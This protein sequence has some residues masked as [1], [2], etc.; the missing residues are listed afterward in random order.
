MQPRDKLRLQPDERLAFLQGFLRRPQQVG[1][2]IPSSRFLERRLVALADVK[3]AR[4][5][6]ELGPGTGGTTRALLAALPADAKLLCIELDPNFAALL[7]RESDP[8]L[9]VHLGSAEQLAEVLAAY[10]LSAPDAVISG[11]PFSTIPPAVGARIIESIRAA[12]APNGCF[13]AYQ[14]RGKVAE[15]ARPVLGAPDVTLELLNIPPVRVF[16]WHLGGARARRAN[17][18]N[19]AKHSRRG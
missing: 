19:T 9:I 6:V 12:L 7:Q 14:V 1:S 15:L 5:V 2:V 4:L 10:Q 16:R 8:R 3:R 18:A 17:S 13:V 11:I